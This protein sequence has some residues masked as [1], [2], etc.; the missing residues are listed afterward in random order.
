MTQ[1]SVPGGRQAIDHGHSLRPRIVFFTI[2]S[3]TPWWTYLA[4]QID[5]AD[6]TVLSDLRGVGDLSL[7]E[8]F[9]RFMKKGDAAA[10][11]VARFGEAGCNDII[12]RCRS[13]R[14]LE[15]DLA[16]KM[17]GGMTQAVESA[18]DALDPRLIVTYTID[19]YVLDV[20]AR[21]A[22]ARG[23]AFLEMT[24]SPIPGQVI[25]QRRGQPIPLRDPS[26]AELDEAVNILCSKDFAPV[27]VR[28]AKRFSAGRFWRVFALY[29]VRGAF[30]N[31]WRHLK[32]DPLN[33]HYIDALKRLK[34]KV[35]PADVAVLGLLRKD[36]QARLESV[37]KDRRVFCGLQLYPEASLDYW[38]KAPDM[39]AYDDAI[40]RYCEVLGRAGYH[41]FIK[42]HPLQF[43]FRQR[44][45]F[46]RLSKLS[47]V[48]CV[49]YGVTANYLLERCA[50]SVTLTGTTGYQAALA[51][52]CSVVTEP[53]YAD[54]E[55]YLHVRSFR[56][57]DDV[58]GRIEAWQPPA[59]L[60]ATRRQIVR[61][62]VAAG[63]AGDYF[64]WKDFDPGD[65]EHR[66]AVQSLVQ[67]FNRHLPRF[68]KQA[69]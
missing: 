68:V 1:Q 46:A 42:D 8:D 2:H 22:A 28:E 7:V 20:T 44:G 67:S 64:T 43:G 12:M 61:K 18:F 15:R 33:V 31:A 16:L 41:I 34:H 13:L 37:P 14:S 17:I 25:F 54:E 21:V 32:R 52:L 3:T 10:V 29:T 59:D 48:T 47:A 65:E 4:S 40:V 58:V 9:Y 53:Y 39:L 49:P 36:W 55:H 50:V 57:I 38:L 5:F 62:L 27:Y 35:R 30:F 51:G 6:V 69:G 11:A 60:D 19:R 56:E 45:L 24:A 63:T 23:I 66:K 26:R